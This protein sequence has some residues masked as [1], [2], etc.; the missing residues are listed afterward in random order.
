[1]TDY[2]SGQFRNNFFKYFKSHFH[3]VIE[4]GFGICNKYLSAQDTRKWGGVLGRYKAAYSV[5]M[6]RRLF[7]IYFLSKLI[8]NLLV[9]SS[10]CI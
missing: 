6:G 4:A 2:K 10:Y 9:L 3:Y 7:T 1:M 8:V 5:V